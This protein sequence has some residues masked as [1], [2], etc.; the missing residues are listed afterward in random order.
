MGFNLDRFRRERVYRCSGPIRELRADLDRLRILDIGV[1]QR[2]RSWGL[3]ALLCLGAAAVAILIQRMF[4]QDASVLRVS[5][6]AASVLVAGA[7]GCCA[8]FLRFKRLDLENRRY[9]LASQLLLRLRHDIG[10]DAPVKLVLDLTPVDAPDKQKGKHVTP[11]GWKAQDF[12]DPWFT[13]QTRLLDGTYL[14]IGMVECLQKRSRVRRTQTGKYKYKTCEYS[15]AFIQVQLRVKPERYP[16]LAR[17]EPQARQA[18]RL[19]DG[20]AVKRLK[21]SKDR[22]VL[23]TFVEQRWSAGHAAEV[24]EAVEAP[25]AVVMMLL[26]LYQVLNYSKHLRKQGR[27]S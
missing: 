19:P 18:L 25:R 24:G 6:S 27:A 17:L 8:M 13:L 15:W 9:T 22:M 10:A 3:A 12:S 5:L 16:N 26:S 23:R 2:R 11:S 20:V 1:E 14:R 7:A 21:L 4:P